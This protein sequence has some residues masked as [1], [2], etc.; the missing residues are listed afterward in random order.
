MF[1]RF[2]S[3]SPFR[4]HQNQT[5]RKSILS[6][7]IILN[8]LFI[9]GYS[10][11]QELYFPHK[12][13]SDSNALY[14]ELPQLAKQV[15]NLYK[16][17]NKTTYYDN[18]FRYQLAAGDYSK[19]LELIDSARK[20]T[21]DNPGSK[22][23]AF[24]P[25]GYAYA[26]KLSMNDSASFNQVYQKAFPE[27]YNGLTRYEKISAESDFDTFTIKETIKDFNKILNAIRNKNS[28]SISLKDA[29]SLTR[30]YVSYIVSKT[31]IPLARPF[32]DHTTLK[33]GYP[34]Y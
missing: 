34:P 14:K 10:F 23:I 17:S 5:M 31:I 8:V 25:E 21:E 11:S 27:L 20:Y 9:P 2:I 24:R 33:M 15:I 26:K 18:A 29:Q 12:L 28:D 19:S 6:A 22:L 1:Y 13:Y 30:N 16:D 7:I 32:L 3:Q 4:K